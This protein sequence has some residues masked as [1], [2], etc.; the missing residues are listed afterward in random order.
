MALLKMMAFCPRLCL[1]MKAWQGR[2][3]A[4]QGRALVFENWSC[5]AVRLCPA[6]PDRP[7]RNE[8]PV[9]RRARQAPSSKPWVPRESSTPR[10]HRWQNYWTTVSLNRF[11]QPPTA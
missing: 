3:E 5:P 8:I 9:A 6:R 7:R 1:P 2:L 4:W 10:Q 11:S